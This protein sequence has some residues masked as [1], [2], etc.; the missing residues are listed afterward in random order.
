MKFRITLIFI[1]CLNCLLSLAQIHNQQAIWKKVDSETIPRFE[2]FQPDHGVFDFAGESTM[3]LVRSFTDKFGKQHDR[4]H[5]FHKN[6]R[7][8]GASVVAHS[9]NNFVT[10]ING[11]W[12]ANLPSKEEKNLL[13][14]EEATKI[15]AMMMQKALIEKQKIGQKQ[16]VEPRNVQVKLCYIDMQF[17]LNSGNIVLAYEVTQT[18][19]IWKLPFKMTHYLDAAFG[20]PIVSLDEMMEHKSKGRGLTN[21]YGVVSFD[22]DS[23]APDEFH[24]RDFSRG[25]G[26]FIRNSKTIDGYK[27]SNSDWTFTDPNEKAAI[28]VMY[29]AQQYYDLLQDRFQFNSLDNQGF[30]L[31]GNVNNILLNN[32]YWDGAS[33]TYGAGDCHDYKSFTSLDV[34]G[35]EFT[36]GLTDFNSNLVYMGESGAIN[37]SISDIFGKALEFYVQPNNFSWNLGHKVVRLGTSPFRSM[38]NPNAREQPKYYKGSYWSDFIYDVHTN[39]GVLNYWFYLLVKGGS[40][41]NEKNVVFNVKPIGMDKALDIVFLLNT[42]YLTETS[43]YP[44]IY[45]FSKILVEDLYGQESDELASVIEAWKAVGLPVVHVENTNLTMTGLLNG[46]PE[47]NPFTCWQNPNPLSFTFVNNSQVVIPPDASVDI[48]ITA[49]YNYAGTSKTDTLYNGKHT[50]QDS[51]RFGQSLEV[52]LDFYLPP[53]V[54]QVGLN[55][56]LKIIF[57]G[58]SYNNTFL[59]A[60]AFINQPDSPE[61]Y[62]SPLVLGSIID[63]ICDQNS[64]ISQTTATLDYLACENNDFIFEFEFSDGQLKISYFDTLSVRVNRFFSLART[65]IQ[66]PDLSTFEKTS[67]LTVDL[68]FWLKGQKYYVTS[69]TLSQRFLRPI[70]ENDTIQ[71]NQLTNIQEEIRLAVQPCIFCPVELTEQN[72]HIVNEWSNDEINDC[73]SI[74]DFYSVIYDDPFSSLDF[75]KIIGCTHAESMLDPYLSFD[76]EL[77]STWSSGS[78]DHRHGLLIYEN[79]V[80]KTTPAITRSGNTFQRM[81]IPIS[82]LPKTKIDFDIYLSGAGIKLDNIFIYDKF[83]SGIHQPE[84]HAH[85]LVNNPASDFITIQAKEKLQYPYSISFYAMNGQPMFSGLLAGE[86]TMIDCSGWPSGLY[87]YE[88]IGDKE[89]VFGKQMIIR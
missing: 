71:F 9:K 79:G 10:D 69:D 29:G 1:F 84:I 2:I 88:I 47:L 32:A 83:Y 13:Q 8:I 34:V 24:L 30:A 41:I 25:D 46:S 33:T 22:H 5:Q 4:Y 12:V 42:A 40:G 60:M 26:I 36:H 31:I 16:A 89:S 59:K 80:L 62:F 45:E 86:K 63:N 73:I 53:P 11:Y 50:L 82:S 43:T 56:N 28:D 65:Y 58:T 19:N 39:S 78:P 21:Y 64:R 81:E 38:S 57:P 48:F 54:S 85:F 7:V 44:D 72:L 20:T 3:Q 51:L 66:N 23:I 17:P 67:D 70:V 52:S 68:Y 76:V 55:A 6:R 74:E 35:H 87:T 37:E 27:N 18:V 14:P 49:L 61:N 75:S 15:A 77:Y